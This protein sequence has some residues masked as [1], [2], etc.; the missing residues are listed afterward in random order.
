MESGV[1]LLRRLPLDIQLFLINPSQGSMS[2]APA[3]QESQLMIP[4]VCSGCLTQ[5]RKRDK[6][7][8]KK[9]AWAS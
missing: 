9:S 5:S 2:L 4:I 6:G 8:Q 1:A 3:H 7:E